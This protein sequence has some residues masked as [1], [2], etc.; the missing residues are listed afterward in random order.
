MQGNRCIWI[1]LLLRTILA[2]DHLE[3]LVLHAVMPV[4][5]ALISVNNAS[6]VEYPH[7]LAPL[8]YEFDVVNLM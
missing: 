5:A 3:Q 1:K 4:S 6:A 8:F 7:D 2:H